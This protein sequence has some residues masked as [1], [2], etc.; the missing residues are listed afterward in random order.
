MIEILTHNIH[1][2]NLHKNILFILFIGLFLIPVNSSA[3]RKIITGKVTDLDGI[4]LIGVTIVVK[5]TTTGTITSLTGDFS[6]IL[7]AG[8]EEPVLVISYIGYQTLEIRAGNTEHFDLQLQEKSELLDEVVVVGYGTQRKVD[9][10]GSVSS[11]NMSKLETLPLS[12]VDQ[13]LQGRVA[14]VNITQNTGAPGEGV[15]VRIRGVGSINSSNS[16]LYIVDGVP[17]TNALDNLAVSDIESVSVLKDAASAAIYGSRANNG[18]VLITTKKGSGGKTTVNFNTQLGIQRHGSLTE[19]TNKNEY[20]EIYNEAANNDNAFISDD[21]LKRPLITPEYAA[22]LPD[23]NHLKEIFQNAIVQNHSLSVSGGN[24]RTRYLL[25]ASHFGQE[26]IILNSDY[27]RTTGKIN[28][29]TDAFEWLEIG[30]NINISEDENNIIGSSGDGYGGNG[31]SVVRY[32]FFR[33]PAIPVYDENGEF[34]DLPDKPGFFGDGYSPVG[35]ALNQN[36]VRK[37]TRVFGDVNATIKFSDNLNLVSTLGIDKANFNQRRFDKNWGTN[38]RINNPNTLTVIDGEIMNWSWSNALTYHTK[39]AED[40]HLSVM[41]GTELIKGYIYQNSASEKDFPDQDIN[42]VYLGNGQGTT[43]ASE[44]REG[45]ALASI[46]GRANYNYKDKYLASAVIREDGS[47]RFS[48]ENRWG[49]FYSLSAGWRL[50]KEDF[51]ENISLIHLL[52]LRASFGAIGNQEVGYYAYSDQISPNYNYPF[53]GVSSDGYATSVY[54]NADIQWETSNQWDVGID[55]GLLNNRINFTA[56]YFHKITS[57]MLTQEPIPPS[58]G[59]IE[60]AWVNKGKIL[61]SGFEF[62]LNVKQAYENGLVSVSGMLAILN[63]EVLE[64]DAPISGGRIDNGVYATLTEVG[65]TVGSFYLYEMEGIF[66]NDIDIVTH[67][68]Q[69]DKIKPGDVM[70]KDQNNDG[71]INENDRIHVGSAIPDF[72]LGLNIM[73]Q[74]KGFDFT[75]F[76]Q[77]GYGNKIYYQIATDIEGFYRPFTVTQRYFDERWT[78]EGTSNTQPR[79]SWAAKSNNTKPSTRFLEDGSYLR[80]KNLQI[81]YTVPVERSH[82]LYIDRIRVYVIGQN[83][84][85]FTKYPGLDPEMTVSD[86]STAEGDRAAGI[87]WGTYPSAVSLSI[88]LQLTF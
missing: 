13:A 36:N 10:T 37:E 11:V 50:D 38:D 22:T 31:G 7:P 8:I 40:H 24:D 70:Y 85:T 67:A 21:L 53:G 49:T 39:L 44:S 86:N 5:G 57:N 14:G 9:L 74:Y 80:L 52:K 35:L 65:H 25:S 68:Y 41:L 79:A 75:L 78:G 54:G 27:Q 47:S 17:T 76:A 43:T 61:N 16:P 51:F 2:I 15:S 20:V 62:E 60:P 84:L 26:G 46:F 58:G 34:V 45:Y 87:G 29:S 19:M 71:I 59:S 83:L 33:T 81:G 72:T 69:G 73:V 42:L 1:F 18:V 55:L 28:L 77:G 63:N 88:G 6:L 66:Q 32:A 12:S 4:E 23:V 82:N 56:D 48:P 30:T 3:Q 64:L